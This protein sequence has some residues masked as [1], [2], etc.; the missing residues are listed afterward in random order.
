MPAGRK[1]TPTQLRLVRGNPGKRALPK[2]EPKPP[3]PKRITPP[4]HLSPAAKKEYR[5]I[6]AK[7]AEVGVLGETDL[8][9]LELYSETYAQWVEATQRVAA[10]GMVIKTPSGFPIMNPY[11]VVANGASKRMQSLLAEFG[12]TP[13]SRTRLGINDRVPPADPTRK[14]FD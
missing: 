1:P 5:R 14:F 10:V 12:M 7:L 2:D 11:L 6:G 8:R 9:A 13:S 3:A 4:S